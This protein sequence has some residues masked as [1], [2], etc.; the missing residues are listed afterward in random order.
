[1]GKK[2]NRLLEQQNNAIIKLLGEMKQPTK[3]QSALEGDALATHAWAS[4]GDYRTPPKNLIL[5][6]G[7]PAEEAKRRD[8]MTNA[9]ATGTAAFGADTSP[10]L[11][12]NKQFINDKNARDDAANYQDNVRGAMDRATNIL[13]ETS[14]MEMA[15]RNAVL[16]GH[17][18]LMST[19]MQR[20]QM[21]DQ[22]RSNIM[23]SIL[24]GASIGLSAFGL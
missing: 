21:A 5:N 9:S 17:Q 18:N 16:G 13:G 1:M 2:I 6:L 22:S 4:G 7:N 15:N 23:N 14:N 19:T 12:L 3:G 24:G 11:Q 10:A 20:K 8:M